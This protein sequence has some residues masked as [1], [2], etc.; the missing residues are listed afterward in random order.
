[1]AGLEPARPRG[2]GGRRRVG[3]GAVREREGAGRRCT[4]RERQG[5]CRIGSSQLG[6]V[7]AG[8]V[9]E[10]ERRASEQETSTDP[11]MAQY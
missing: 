11:R 6:R 7:M 4:V 8:G 5:D 9:S 1:M 10:Q 3:E 2:E